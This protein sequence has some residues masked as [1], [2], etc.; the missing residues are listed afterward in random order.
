MSAATRA[1][2]LVILDCDGVLFDSGEANV[3]FYDAILA[4]MG[5]PPLDEEGR[6]LAHWVASPELLARL[7]AHDPQQHEMARRIAAEMDYAR[8]LPLMRPAPRLVETLAWLRGRG[9]TAL[10]TNRSS[11]IPTLLA[12]FGLGPYFDLVVGIHDVPRPKPAPDML[13]H[14][15]ERFA[16][17]PDDAVFVGDSASD[18]QAALHAGV[19]FITVGVAEPGE[20]SIASLAELPALLD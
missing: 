6:E 20:R 5:L 9:K 19:P 16:L 14:C 13:L 11:T 3:G 12:H 18:R 15:L 8:F 17:A 2:Q 7:F 10:A 4:E 1:P